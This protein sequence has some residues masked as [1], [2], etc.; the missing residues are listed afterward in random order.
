[1]TQDAELSPLKRAIVEIRELKA[2]VA[3][4][5]AR[6]RE[7]IAIVGMGLRF[8][9]G[10]DDPDSFWQLLVDGVDAIT[11]VPPER[12]SIDALYDPDPDRPGHMATRYG[13]FLRDVD[14]F[15]APFFG[16]SPREAETM[17][18]QQRL[19]L[20]VAWEALEHAGVAA[21]RL[22]GSKTGVFVGVT[23]T[24]YARMLLADRDQIDTY[25]STGNLPSVA[26]GRL[27]Y[28]LGLEGPSVTLDTACSSSLVAA[29]LAAQSLRNQECD[30]ALAGG[31]GLILAPEFT[32]NFSRARMMAPDGRCKTF[33]AA[34]DG[35]VRSEGCG[36][37]VL[38]RLSDAVADGDNVQ[39]VIRGSAINQDGRSGGLTAPNGPSQERVIAA[40]LVNAGVEPSAVSYVETHGTGTPL[41]DPIEVR[42]LGAALCHDRPADRPL[43]L[44]SVK[45][46][47]GHLE[48]AAGVASLIKVVLMLQHGTIPPHLHLNELSPYIVSEQLPIAVPTEPTPWPEPAAS[49]IA[50]VS[51]FGISGT[52]AHLIVGTGPVAEAAAQPEP[53]DGPA[54][55][56]V[57]LSTRSSSGLG[58]LAGRYASH[59]AAH[60]ELHLA[61]VAA[62]ANNTR[63][64][65]SHRLAVVA[66]DEPTLQA[67][68]AAF[69]GGD[70][71]A[72][73]TGPPVV[74][75]PEVAFV[76]TGHGSQHVGMGRELYATNGVFRAAIDRC[77]ELL[78]DTLDHALPAVLFGDD[79]LLDSMRY[80]QPA[81]FAFQYALAELWRSWGVQ[82]S[83][84]AGHSAGEYAAAVIAQTLT[85]EDGLRVVAARGRLMSTL[86][87]DGEMVAA[88]L[89]EERVAEAVARRASDVGIAAVNGPTTTV[90]SGTREGVDAV[91]ADLALDVDDYRRLDVSVA[92]HS[93]LVEPILDDFERAVQTV[94][95]ARP[96]LG[97]VSSM[98]GAIVSAELTDAGYW[99]R[100]L[101]QPVRFA[102]VF[103]TMRTAGYTTFVEIGP[104]PTLIGLGRRS[105]PDD[106][107]TWAPSMERDADEWEVLLT[108]V[109]A[110]HVAGVDV[111]LTA[112]EPSA[113]RRRV[114]LPTYPW[115]RESYWAPSADHR[116]QPAPSIPAWPAIVAAVESQADQA[117]LDLRVDT[118]AERWALMDR[119][120]TAAIVKAFGSMGLYSAQGE[121]HR[122]DELVAAGHFLPTYRHLAERWLGHLADDG[123]LIRAADGAFR[124]ATPL[125]DADLDALLADAEPVFTGAEALLEYLQ[126][127]TGRLAAVVAGEESALTTLFP[128]GSYDTVDFL[129]HHWAV[130]RYFNGIVRAAVVAVANARPGET[131]RVLEVGA[132]TGGTAAALLPALPVERTSYTFTDVSDFF[133]T[134]A[135][136]RFAAHPF[137]RYALLDLEREP[138]EQ[139]FGQASYDVVV[140]AN[141]L[142]ATSNLDHTLTRVRDLLAPGGSLLAYEATRHFAWFDV[143]TGLIEGWQRFDD[144][145]RDDNPLIPPDKWAAALSAAGF[146]EVLTLPNRDQSTAVLGQ[147]VVVARAPGD[148]TTGQR[149]DEGDLV[150]TSTDAHTAAGV[151]AVPDLETI[152]A[153]LAEALPDERIDVLVGVVRMA[154]ARVL[155]IADPSRL[156]R[157]QPL[158]ELGFDSL[159]AVELRNVLREAFALE[160]KLPA[161]LVFDHPNIV[162]IAGYLD[163]LLDGDGGANDVDT[164]TASADTPTA[165]VGAE[166]VAALSDEQVEAMLLEKLANLQEST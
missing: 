13:G 44:G 104:H 70:A 83:I 72:V 147:H 2:R 22:A 137:V 42:A 85:L 61:D 68:L 160:R 39:A 152:S 80:A 91:L 1:M 112:V 26:T 149:R 46:N 150:A 90:I 56:V 51:S 21:D 35:Y 146:V 124:S 125:P 111:D 77:D 52:N 157:D 63:A 3:E 138:T 140:A 28:V 78:G 95:L 4:V 110:L 55:H 74:S 87:T 49:R 88:F 75:T 34:A 92:A 105:W 130:A 57:T 103:E 9:G 58:E 155:R 162:A 145:W 120:A 119:I 109:A 96:Q 158:L 159:M 50:G 81:L 47:V 117:P 144:E 118:Y 128:D 29:H 14:R 151:A 65:L 100:H 163:R 67:R 54:N 84:V 24:D 89:D 142:H 153:A 134:R 71:N 30:V 62:S 141:V 7:P 12:W 23:N 108:S 107:A 101:R 126:R 129:Y 133:L 64:H 98:T 99:R 15:D 79:G 19:L 86:A 6:A 73:V 10:A 127:C 132:G 5:D 45:T 48:S 113:G 18:P 156:R 122:V 139:G 8:P 60:P 115:Q 165:P 136:D 106:T 25:T 94:Q 69:A 164:M 93:P 148:D 16:I 32:I 82:P 114:N 66:S 41:G 143:T 102:D 135:A 11:E 53:V 123:L 59:L 38:K 33:D 27:S 161:T 166:T 154:I 20:E 131:L 97:L 40:A 121:Q 31:V 36:V 17:D 43:L 37:V 76:F 116:P